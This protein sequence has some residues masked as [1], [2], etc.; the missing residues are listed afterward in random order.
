MSD[1]GMTHRGRTDRGRGQG[2]SNQA[3]L[4]QIWRLLSNIA[5]DDESL[6]EVQYSSRGIRLL[7]KFGRKTVKQVR[8]D[9]SDEFQTAFQGKVHVDGDKITIGDLRDAGSG[10]GPLAFGD[11]YQFFDTITIGLDE[12]TKFEPED[13]TVIAA[14]S[15][16]YYRLT[17]AGAVITAALEHSVTRPVQ[18]HGTLFVILGKA[19]IT[20]GVM[21]WKQYWFGDIPIWG[22]FA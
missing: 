4:D 11:E 9:A 14:T 18:V 3:D 10:G 5:S 13:T 15:F 1:Q 19:T 22:R 12:L 8:Q 2:F 6:L 7:P 21:R 17:K 16:V 20:S